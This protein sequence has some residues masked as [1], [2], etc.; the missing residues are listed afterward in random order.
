MSMSL[1]TLLFTSLQLLVQVNNAALL[2]PEDDVLYTAHFPNGKTYTYDT[3]KGHA[4]A[5][6]NGTSA[7]ED[8]LDAHN[9]ARRELNL[10]ELVSR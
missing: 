1:T 5:Y 2:S 4:W 6:W 3:G 8:I 9:V 10:T 7:D